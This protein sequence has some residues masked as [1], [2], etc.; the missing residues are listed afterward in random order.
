MVPD[1]GRI[2]DK[3][4]CAFDSRKHDFPKIR[5]KDMQAVFDS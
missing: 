4:R 2:A 5:N 1:I 3:E